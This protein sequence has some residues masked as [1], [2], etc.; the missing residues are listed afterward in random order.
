MPSELTFDLKE[1][2]LSRKTLWEC[3]AKCKIMYYW[4]S[5]GKLKPFETEDKKNHIVSGNFKL[6]EVEI[7]WDLPYTGKHSFTTWE[8]WLDDEKIESD[9]YQ[10]TFNKNYIT[11]KVA[12]GQG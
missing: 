11:V 1:T 6:Q 10:Y 7:E 2:E 4:D 3:E 8:L 12:I 5:H 9:V